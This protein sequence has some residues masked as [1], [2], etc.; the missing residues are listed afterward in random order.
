MSATY[1]VTTAFAAI[2]LLYGCDRDHPLELA[3]AANV[4][5]DNVPAADLVSTP[6][7]RVDIQISGMPRL[8]QPFHVSATT[9]GAVGTSDVHVTLYAPEIITAIG[10]D[11][12]HGV[13]ASSEDFAVHRTR[14]I[15]RPS[16]TLKQEAILTIEAPGYY[17]ILT[18]A[19]TATGKQQPSTRNADVLEDF[20]YL[21]KWV[22][23]DETG[24][25][26]TDQFE[27][28]LLPDSVIKQPGVFRSARPTTAAGLRTNA[29]TG[30][31]T[32]QVLY[33]DNVSGLYAPLPYAKVSGT[34]GGPSG[35]SPVNA[36]TN[37]NGEFTTGCDEWGF[38]SYDLDVH[39]DHALVTISPSTLIGS[40]A[41][42]PA[43]CGGEQIV[44]QSNESNVF[45]HMH[46]AIANSNNFFSRGRSKVKV[47]LGYS[48]SWSYYFKD[49]DY[50]SLYPN[51]FWDDLGER[52]M[53][54]E[55]GHAFH[56][57]G[58]GGLPPVTNCPSTHAP[59]IYSSLG[60]ALSEG[61]AEYVMVVARPDVSSGDWVTYY[62]GNA[63]LL[64]NSNP[65]SG[66]PNDPN[67]SILEGPVTA[68][69]VDLTDAANESHDVIQYAP[70]YI[71]DVLRTCFVSDGSSNEHA[72]G[73]DHVIRCLERQVDSSINGYFYTRSPASVSYSESA[74]EPGAW[75]ASNIR[76]LWKKNLYNQ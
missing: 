71:A 64:D 72:N 20:S 22:L 47:D 5:S 40:F 21:E 53:A 29:Q 36:V 67:G 9:T 52:A 11:W 30:V 44:T 45:H 24:S 26:I 8:R 13:I 6:R 28:G 65:N 38:Y 35:T 57:K 23:I 58:L 25:T 37:Y 18:T 12:R 76:T 2:L 19:R 54:H 50:I 4:A 1:R 48:A 70:S 7:F 14:G 41:G 32:W 75:S 39:A 33:F 3:S 16:T 60:C 63:A 34:E 68:L 27:P 55:Y 61:F 59:G 62:E 66:D 43:G 15:V 49:T 10:S 73:V 56:E 51:H 17:R 42:G 31:R 69:L 74:S 46:K